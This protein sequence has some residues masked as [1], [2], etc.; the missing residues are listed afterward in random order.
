MS[1]CKKLAGKLI[2]SRE[3]S[4]I[5]CHLLWLDGKI[6]LK[7]NQKFAFYVGNGLIYVNTAKNCKTEEFNY[8]ISSL[9]WTI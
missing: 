9:F 7:F 8:K 4:K 1:N 3:F 5:R 6:S 2:R